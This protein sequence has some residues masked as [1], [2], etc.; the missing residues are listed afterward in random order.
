M[1]VS[2]II[3]LYNYT[4]YT[5]IYI[6]IY[7]Y[8]S[9]SVCIYTYLSLNIYIYIYVYMYKPSITRGASRPAACLT[10][11]TEIPWDIIGFGFLTFNIRPMTH[12]YENKIK[13][14]FI[15]SVL[16]NGVRFFISVTLESL[17]VSAVLI[18]F[19]TYAL[20]AGPYRYRFL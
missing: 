7:I 16:R 8:I 5:C 13:F 9:L 1:S 12:I 14:V 10:T 15:A 2:V 17:L 19:C 18:S 3:N 11:T 20:L 4:S 6:Y